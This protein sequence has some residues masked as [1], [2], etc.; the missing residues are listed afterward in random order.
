MR[1]KRRKMKGEMEVS[2]KRRLWEVES[3]ETERREDV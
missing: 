3:A 1:K 2:R